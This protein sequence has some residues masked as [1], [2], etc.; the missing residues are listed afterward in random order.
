MMKDKASLWAGVRR[1]ED[2]LRKDP[3]AYSFAPL[4]DIYRELGLLEDALKIARKGCG[5]H[6]DFAAGQ[7]ALARAAFESA[8]KD[9]ARRALEAV[10]RITP[11]NLEA[12]RLLADIYSAD[13]DEAAAL[14]C[15]EIASSLDTLQPMPVPA[16]K[17]DDEEILDA[18]ILE[19]TDDQIE[20]EGIDEP[21]ISP[22]SADPERPSLGDAVRAEPYLM[23]TPP[24]LYDDDQPAADSAFVASATIAELYV[25]QG[26][27][28]K[29]VKIYQELLHAD[30]D[31]QV[32]IR[33]IEELLHPVPEKVAVEEQLKASAAAAAEES[34]GSQ[35]VMDT[36]N[37]WLTNIKGVRE[38][39]TKIF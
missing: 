3:V 35:N 34:A 24:P 22:F 14:R 10:I 17:V 27:A 4:S 30:P 25:S 20:M 15:L 18:D 31:N 9:E 36:L 33:R 8:L 29:G 26:F 28:E 2:I 32:F 5:L 16:G 13:G 38:C 39:R 11:E 19:L 6:P 23:E 37:D 1:F 7:M 21:A 12:Q